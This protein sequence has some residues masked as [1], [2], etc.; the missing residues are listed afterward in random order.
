MLKTPSE[1]TLPRFIFRWQRRRKPDSL[2]FNLWLVGKN[3]NPG[4]GF[5]VKQNYQGPE[6]TV[7]YGWLPGNESFLRHHKILLSGNTWLNTVTGDH[8]TTNALCNGISAPKKDMKDLLV[9]YVESGIPAGRTYF[10][11]LPGHCS[12]RGIFV[13]QL[14]RPI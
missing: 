9:H 2:R 13:Y 5:E 14:Q 12:G 3:F 11:K 1:P 4:I 8:E 6:G 7:Q 10:G